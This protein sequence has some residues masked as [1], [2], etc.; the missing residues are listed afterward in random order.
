MENKKSLESLKNSVCSDMGEDPK[1]WRLQVIYGMGDIRGGL[2][3]TSS[4]ESKYFMFNVK[5][6]E[7]FELE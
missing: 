3:P 1:D 4:E 7:R 2:A 5:T 6:K